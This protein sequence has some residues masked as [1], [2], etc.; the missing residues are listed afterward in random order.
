MRKLGLNHSKVTTSEPYSLISLKVYGCVHVQYKGSRVRVSYRV[1]FL[2][3]HT[4]YLVI[5]KG[6]GQ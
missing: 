2:Y 6:I 1:D 5:W 4:D 3:L